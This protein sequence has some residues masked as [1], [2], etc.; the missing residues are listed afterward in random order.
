MVK[1]IVFIIAFICL[2]GCFCAGCAT[3]R[4]RAGTGGG[5][6]IRPESIEAGDYALKDRI[7]QLEQQIA[8]ARTEV[9]ELR[10]SGQRIRDA[11]G[12]S[13]DLV[14]GIIE[15]MEALSEWIDWADSRLQYLENLLAS[16]VQ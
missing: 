13:V 14:Q 7:R 10:E 3:V 8:G 5:D 2:L 12:R 4:E 1:K 16:E 11:S 9:R 6:Y 15:K